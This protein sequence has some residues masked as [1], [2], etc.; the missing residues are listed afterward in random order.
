VAL[1]GG[2]GAAA[3]AAGADQV[4]QLPFDPR[5]FTAEVTAALG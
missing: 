1:V 5:T 3:L 2:N 4:V